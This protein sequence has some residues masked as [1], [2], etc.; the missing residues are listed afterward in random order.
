MLVEIEY[1]EEEKVKDYRRRMKE[2]RRERWSDS[3]KKSTDKKRRGRSEIRSIFNKMRA[4]LTQSQ[5][6]TLFE[7]Y[8]LERI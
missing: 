6:G 2:A 4:T 1:L 3:R 8:L 5:L 7:R